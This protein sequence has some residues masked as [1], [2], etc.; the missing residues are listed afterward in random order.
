MDSSKNEDFLVVELQR[1]SC[2]TDSILE[3]VGGYT[4]TLVG[5]VGFSDPRSSDL[6]CFPLMLLVNLASEYQY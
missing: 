3:G 2:S 5:S 6:L 4:G 1:D